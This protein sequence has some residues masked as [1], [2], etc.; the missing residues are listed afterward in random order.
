MSYTRRRILVD[1]ITQSGQKFRPSDWAERLSES[2]SQVGRDHRIHYS[3]YV[4]PVLIE[5]HAGLKIDPYLQEVNPR[6]YKQ[7]MDFV[8]DNKLVILESCDNDDP[9]GNLGLAQAAAG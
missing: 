6:A 2:V 8:R 3:P 9:E 1:G 7:I 4:E 5:G